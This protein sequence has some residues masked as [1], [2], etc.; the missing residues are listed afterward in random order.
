MILYGTKNTLTLDQAEHFLATKARL[1]ADSIGFGDHL[2]TAKDDRV[3]DQL[4][5]HS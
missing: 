4:Q 5:Y 2:E 3:G 1:L